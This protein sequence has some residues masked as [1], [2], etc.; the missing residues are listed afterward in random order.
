[1]M[2]DIECVV[3]CSKC[4]VEKFTVYRAPTGQN[5]VFENQIKWP[6]T[7]RTDTKICLDCKEPLSRKE[8][9]G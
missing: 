1:M 7:G 5:G 8:D 4:R 6:T 3:W 9:H 2:P